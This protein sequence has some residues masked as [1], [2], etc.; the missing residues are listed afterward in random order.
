M[1]NDWSIQSRGDRCAQTG[2]PFAEGEFFYTVLYDEKNGF[3]REDLCEAAWEERRT[4]EPLP[5]SFWRTKYEPPPPAAPE[6]IGKQ[7]AE[8]LLRRLIAENE[9]NREGVRYILAVM[10]E[11]KRQL[12]EVEAKRA[13][14]GSLARVYEHSKTGEVFVIRDPE[15]RL[16]QIAEVQ[17]QIADLLK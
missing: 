2:T 11:R 13:E 17:L 5:F 1:I 3:R 7:T 6:P 15:L 9:P 4:V 8:D 10:L 14:D 16:D 12:K